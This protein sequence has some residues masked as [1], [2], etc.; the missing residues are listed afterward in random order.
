MIVREKSLIWPL[1]TVTGGDLPVV[2]NK[3]LLESSTMDSVHPNLR[4]PNVIPIWRKWAARMTVERANET[5]PLNYLIQWP[6]SAR[7]LI[8]QIAIQ[9]SKK[10]K[11]PIAVKRLMLIA[12]MPMCNCGRSKIVVHIIYIIPN[13]IKQNKSNN[14]GDVRYRTFISKE[15]SYLCQSSLMINL[16]LRLIQIFLSTLA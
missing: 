5:N 12:K 13:N 9:D 10:T 1:A 2:V 14:A 3:R 6:N 4:D 16:I 8:P 11:F 7:I 15:P